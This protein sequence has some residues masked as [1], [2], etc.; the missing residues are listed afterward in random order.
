MSRIILL[1]ALVGLLIVNSVVLTSLALF[2]VEI[3]LRCCWGAQSYE[4]GSDALSDIMRIYY[5]R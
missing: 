2:G 1:L 3:I 5:F 4:V